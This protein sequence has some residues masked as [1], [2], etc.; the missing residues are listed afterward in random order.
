MVGTNV[1]KFEGT[2]LEVKSTNNLKLQA[3][4]DSKLYLGTGTLQDIKTDIGSRISTSGGTINGNLSVT[5][6]MTL[7]SL[8]SSVGKTIRIDT[9]G[10]LAAGPGYSEGILTGLVFTSVEHNAFQLTNITLSAEKHGRKTTLFFYGQGPLSDSTTKTFVSSSMGT[11]NSD[12]YGP[13]IFPGP[14]YTSMCTTI[15]RDYGN[16]TYDDGVAIINA[17]GNQYRIVLSFSNVPTSS[18]YTIG[19]FSIT[20]FSTNDNLVAPSAQW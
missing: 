1:L 18:P 8:S 14:S 9:G 3:A 4:D 12:T 15:Y 20:Y 16:G 5:G 19:G 11:V 10:N 7:F 2:D 17:S 6:S 13:V